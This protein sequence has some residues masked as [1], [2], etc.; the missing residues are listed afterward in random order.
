MGD[1]CRSC[2]VY[3]V[4]VFCKI[5]NLATHTKVWVVFFVHILLTSIQDFFMLRLYLEV[6]EILIFYF[7]FYEGK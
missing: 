1:Y 7:K 5:N 4:A 6:Y 2:G 3:D